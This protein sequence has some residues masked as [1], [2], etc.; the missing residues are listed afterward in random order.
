MDSITIHTF[1]N[2]YRRDYQPC[3]ARNTYYDKGKELSHSQHYLIPEVAKELEDR[4]L[5]DVQFVTGDE[6]RVHV[7]V[8][9]PEAWKSVQDVVLS[10]LIER[11]WKDRPSPSVIEVRL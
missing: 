8:S 11:F 10:A 5:Q 7:M 4:K 2:P 6:E 9:D 1:H 3:L